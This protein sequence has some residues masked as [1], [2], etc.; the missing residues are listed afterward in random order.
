MPSALELFRQRRMKVTVFT[1][2]D[3]CSELKEGVERREFWTPTGLIRPDCCAACSRQLWQK[4]YGG[5][6]YQ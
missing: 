6:S 4:H 5:F 1:R 3:E 2:C